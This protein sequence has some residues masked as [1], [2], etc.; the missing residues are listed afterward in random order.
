[1]TD[2]AIDTKTAIDVMDA[3]DI[4]SQAGMTAVL[5]HL[6]SDMT[7]EALKALSPR[8]KKNC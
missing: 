4:L 5:A 2:P 7:P 6:V 1:M 3:S 8:R